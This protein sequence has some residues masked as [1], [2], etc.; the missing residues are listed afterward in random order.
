M[1]GYATQ[2]LERNPSAFW[3]DLRTKRIWNRNQIRFSL[4]PALCIANCALCIV[5]CQL[6]NLH[7][8]L[9]IAQPKTQAVKFT[10]LIISKG[11][12]NEFYGC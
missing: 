12:E 6:L 8:A 1:V 10:A 3:R 7:S 4:E 11:I 2:R 9:L 5:H